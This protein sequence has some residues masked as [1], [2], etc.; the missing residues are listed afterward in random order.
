M[1][2]GKV[3]DNWNKHWESFLFVSLQDIQEI[4]IFK[5]AHC[6]V[7]NLKMNTSNALNNSLEKS[8]NQ[9]LN[10]VNFTYFKYFL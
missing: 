10:L 8:W 9:M 3:Y 4:V 2:L 6:S 1:I 5:E 7:C